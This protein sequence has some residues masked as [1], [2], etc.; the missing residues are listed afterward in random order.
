MEK[1][2]FLKN[3]KVETNQSILAKKIKLKTKQ[4]KISDLSDYE[5]QEMIELYKVEIQQKKI[6]LLKYRNKMQTNKKEE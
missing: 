1:D 3:I 2:I 6:K 4:I 5:L